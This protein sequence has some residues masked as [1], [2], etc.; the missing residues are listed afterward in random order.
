MTDT[1]PLS[2]ELLALINAD[3]DGDLSAMEQA[4]LHQVLSESSAARQQHQRLQEVHQALTDLPH[5]EVPANLRKRVLGRI[6]TPRP[7]ISDQPQPARQH[8]KSTR[9]SKNPGWFTELLGNY[10]QAGGVAIAVAAVMAVGVQLFVY[11]PLDQQSNAAMIGTVLPESKMNLQQ[12][13]GRTNV[14]TA[15]LLASLELRQIR[16]LAN[17][18]A[19]IGSDIDDLRA[20]D[21]QLSLWVEGGSASQLDVHVVS[22]A[23]SIQGLATAPLKAVDS[24]GHT[25]SN[26]QFVLANDKLAQIN[27]LE[28][29]HYFM[30]LRKNKPVIG[31]EK[32]LSDSIQINLVSD[33]KLILNENFETINK[34]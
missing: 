10:W 32:A 14:A 31:H 34:N 30:I 5:V 18:R 13:I 20:T 11:S 28:S 22:E 8:S 19:E 25:L 4:Q 7:V 17:A 24:A 15:E 26:H 12:P 2:P 27:T 23:Y 21:L 16:D 1:A 6:P 3:I 33:N 9:K 29:K